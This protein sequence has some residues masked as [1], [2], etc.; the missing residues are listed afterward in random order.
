MQTNYFV[1]KIRTQIMNDPHYCKIEYTFSSASLMG[2]SDRSK[3]Q[4]ANDWST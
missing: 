4:H 1:I 3:C 2:H